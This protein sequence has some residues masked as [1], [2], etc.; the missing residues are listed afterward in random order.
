MSGFDA[1]EH[2]L[3]LFRDNSTGLL[4]ITLIVTMLSTASTDIEKLVLYRLIADACME[5]P[6][7]VTMA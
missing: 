2:I 4:L 6:E 5:M 7:V 3:I 1:N